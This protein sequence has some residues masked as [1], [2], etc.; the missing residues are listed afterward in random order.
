MQ[1]IRVFS[2]LLLIGGLSA[3]GRSPLLF[4]QERTPGGVLATSNDDANNADP[5]TRYFGSASSGDTPVP[6]NTVLAESVA[7][8]GTCSYSLH[9]DA[10]DPSDLTAPATNSVLA[11]QA[12]VG[13]ADDS[14]GCP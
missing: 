8:T 9:A 13:E 3:C 2:A 5:A 6:T 14:T 4:D 7:A 1:A 11:Q 12:P 10:L